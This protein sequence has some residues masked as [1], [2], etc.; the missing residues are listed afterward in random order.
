[1]RTTK[2]GLVAFE[3]VQGGFCPLCGASEIG[4]SPAENT[5]E[6][7]LV[8][9]ADCGA[10]GAEWTSMYGLQAVVINTMTEEED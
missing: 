3:R 9:T 6:G 8:Q 5:A 1:M 10:C 2:R 7:T 4:E